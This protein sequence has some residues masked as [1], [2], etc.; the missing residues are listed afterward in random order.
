M[1]LLPGVDIHFLGSVE[2]WWFLPEIWEEFQHVFSLWGSVVQT[3]PSFPAD[4]P[5]GSTWRVQVSFTH[6]P[7]TTDFPMH[8]HHLAQDL[9]PLLSNL[10]TKCPPLSHHCRSQPV[11]L[12]FSLENKALMRLLLISFQQ[13]DKS[14]N[15]SL[16]RACARLAA[17]V[18]HTTPFCVP[19]TWASLASCLFP[20]HFTQPFAPTQAPSKVRPNPPC[21]LQSE[22]S[23]KHS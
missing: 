23:V 19:L 20:G 5:A 1:H 22:H 8:L 11:W 10:S 13:L 9:W 21:F 2:H 3:H 7:W 16:S 17:V 14:L 15:P 6:Q 4:H 12:H 18:Q